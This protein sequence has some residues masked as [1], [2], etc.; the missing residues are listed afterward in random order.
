MHP[1]SAAQPRKRPVRDL[2]ARAMGHHQK[3]ELPQAEKYYKRALKVAPDHP[4]ALHLSGLVAHQLGRHPRAIKLISKAIKK[5]C[6]QKV[7]H[8]NLSIIHNELC[9][10]E[11]ARAAATSALELDEDDGEA[12]GN[13]GLA[14]AGLRQIDEALG[15]MDRSLAIAPQNALFLCN[16]ATLLVA[17]EQHKQAEAA[18][19]RALA[20]Q[21]LSALAATALA[22]YL[23]KM[24]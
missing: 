22:V 6:N 2:L 15:A 4:D 5:D 19:R 14:L 11:D 23:K 9:N 18:C 7:F 21:P 17:K 24:I 10:W 20:L 13:L 3:G 16:Q 8:T 1:E 12:W